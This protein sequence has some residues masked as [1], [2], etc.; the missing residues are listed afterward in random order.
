MGRLHPAAR[1]IANDALWFLPVR[2]TRFQSLFPRLRTSLATR[3]NL[4]G[5]LTCSPGKDRAAS[6]CPLARGSGE[7][8]GLMAASSTRAWKLSQ[9]WANC[10]AT[11]AASTTAMLWTSTTPICEGVKTGGKT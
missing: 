3:L 8:A 9:S 6:A 5:P 4:P 2:S 11:R 7:S 10:E 1:T